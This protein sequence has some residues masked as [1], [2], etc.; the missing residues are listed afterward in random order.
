[1]ERRK[2]FWSWGASGW[3]L[4]ALGAALAFAA[5]DFTIVQPTLRQMSQLQHQVAAIDASVRR[6]AGHKGVVGA[7]NSLLAKLSEQGRLNAEASQSLEQISALH[8]R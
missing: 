3:A 6:L 5:I 2:S 8:D 7:T 1:M 4:V